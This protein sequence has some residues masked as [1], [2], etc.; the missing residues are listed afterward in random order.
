MVKLTGAAGTVFNHHVVHFSVA[1]NNKPLEN[2]V[3][4]TIDLTSNVSNLD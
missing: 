3:P 2:K 4:S 1:L